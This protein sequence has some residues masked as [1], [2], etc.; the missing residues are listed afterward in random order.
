MRPFRPRPDRDGSDPPRG[1]PPALTVMEGS[2]AAVIVASLADPACFGLLFERHFDT[3][4]RFAARRVGTDS[5]GDV[6]SETFRVA[7]AARDRFDRLEAN[8]R[9]WLY[10][11]ATNVVRN[12]VRGVG[13]NGRTVDRVGIVGGATARDGVDPRLDAVPAAID[14]AREWL[15]VAAA[16]RTIPPADR[17]A[18]LLFAWEGLS[19]AEVATALDIP[20]GTVRSRI[21]RARSRIRELLDADRQRRAEDTAPSEEDS[22][23]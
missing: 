16:L 18:L 22:H 13:R 19:Y 9:P 23:V 7:F 6:A 14:A 1:E 3:I 21:S 8:A 2:D 12:H 5:A 17:D 15:A 11:I 4:F 10:G 20:V